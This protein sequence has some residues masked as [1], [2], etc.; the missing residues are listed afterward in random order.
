MRRLRGH[1]KC[2]SRHKCRT[3]N[4]HSYRSNRRPG[5]LL[6]LKIPN[7]RDARLE[8]SLKPCQF[9]F[10]EDLPVTFQPD[11]GFLV[12]MCPG[13]R[14]IPFRCVRHYIF[15]DFPPEIHISVHKK[16]RLSNICCHFFIFICNKI[17]VPSL[18]LF[19]PLSPSDLSSW[20][21]PAQESLL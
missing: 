10:V 15:I 16:R 21:L 3:D 9:H 5:Y 7:L 19:H 13:L 4:P 17:S 6:F 2:R 1:R 20:F 14:R 12:L 8:I 11:H 18:C